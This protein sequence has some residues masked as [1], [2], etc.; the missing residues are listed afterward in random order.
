MIGV[1]NFIAVRIKANDSLLSKYIIV[2]INNIIIGDKIYL[3]RT[4]SN[5]KF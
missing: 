1:I 2:K 5:L 3:T 4:N